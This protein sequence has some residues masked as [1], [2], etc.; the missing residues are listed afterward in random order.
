MAD[1]ST[2]QRIDFVT[3]GMFILDDIH[4]SPST[5]TPS[6][7][8]PGGAGTYALLGARL[9]SPPPSTST[10]AMII[11]AGKDF[12]S[13]PLSTIRT[14]S[15][16]SLIRQREG[17]TTRG[18][19]GYSGNEVRAFKYLTPKLRLTA[20]DLN[21]DLLASKSFHLICSPERC[22]TEVNSILSKRRNKGLD[23][24]PVFIWEPVPG[25]CT[26]EELSR[27]L[28]ANKVVDIVSPNHDELAAMFGTE[29]GSSVRVEMVEEHALKMVEHGIGQDGEGAIVV[30]CGAVGCFVLSRRVKKWLPAYHMDGSKVVD[31]TG[32]GNGFLGGLAV[33]LVRTGD[34]V[35]AS[36]WGSV[37]ASLCIEQVGVPGLEDTGDGKGEKWN[38]VD[39]LERLAKFR[40]RTS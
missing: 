37:S 40:S 2:L 26:A 27:T 19:N 39:V 30:R 15:T 38:G 20:G 14:W 9:L 16:S 1:S 6:L 32:G 22:I 31:P 36:R 25:L 13:S 12:P 17:L 23:E 11:D 4:S 33:G 7:S 3:L 28:E 8:I 5:K 34:V 21:A 18:W 35:E 10:V 29:H 24:R